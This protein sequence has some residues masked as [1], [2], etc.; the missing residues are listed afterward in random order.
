MTTEEKDK[1]YRKVSV[2]LGKDKVVE[3]WLHQIIYDNN[4]CPS[5]II[6]INQELKKHYLNNF[7]FLD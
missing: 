3:G 6:E 7:I 2:F 1:K 4:A 5:A